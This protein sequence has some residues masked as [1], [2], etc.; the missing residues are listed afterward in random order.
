MGRACTLNEPNIVATMGYLAGVF[1]PGKSDRDPPADGQR[2]LR[3]RP[4]QGGRGHP[5]GAPGVPVGL[6]LAMSDYQAVDGGESKR[7]Q[8]RRSMEDVFLDATARRRLR[9][10]AD[11]LPQP[12]RPDGVVGGEEGVPTLIM[13]YEYYPEALEATIRRAWEAT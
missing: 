12:G 6:T 8:I 2:R 7:D 4:P 1:P 11:V 9:G 10:R 5:I 13:G 3:R